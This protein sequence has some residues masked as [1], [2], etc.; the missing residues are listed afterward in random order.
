MG[1]R[2]REGKKKKVGGRDLVHIFATIEFH[3][4]LINWAGN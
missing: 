1:V 2:N 4:M 3:V